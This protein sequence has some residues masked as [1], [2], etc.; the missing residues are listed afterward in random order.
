VR[1]FAGDR[2]HHSPGFYRAMNEVPTLLLVA[3][4]ILAVVKPF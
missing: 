3:I 1:D 4:V 2:N